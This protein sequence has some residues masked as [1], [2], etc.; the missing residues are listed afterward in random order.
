VGFGRAGAVAALQAR[1]AGGSVIAV[2]RF[3]GGGTTA[4]SGGV[5]YTGETRYQRG[6]GIDDTAEEMFKYLRLD[7]TVVRA[8]ARFQAAINNG[9][10]QGMICPTTPSGSWE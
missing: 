7:G 3:A 9:K 2:D 6:A 4:K 10:F 5:L 1:E 8:G